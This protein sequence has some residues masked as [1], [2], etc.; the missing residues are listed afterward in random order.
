[1]VYT[2]EKSCEES[3][4]SIKLKIQTLTY[5]IG[6]IQ[7][8]YAQAINKQN[9]TTGSLF[10][11]K[12]KAKQLTE[13]EDIIRCFHYIH[14]NPLKAGLVRLPNEWEFS[15]FTD[16]EGTNQTKLCNQPLL[17]D[18]TACNNKTLLENSRQQIVFTESLF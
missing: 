4:G 10:Q 3:Y 2:T 8:S 13:K 18:L 14:Q 9:R 11:C 16:Y 15:S 5:W 6:I 7:S 1:M 17:H 12:T